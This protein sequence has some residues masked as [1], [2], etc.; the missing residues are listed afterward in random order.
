[1]EGAAGRTVSEVVE[2]PVPVRLEHLGVDVEAAVAE[3]CDFLC[4]EGGAAAEGAPAEWSELASGRPRR[5]IV[6]RQVGRRAKR[7]L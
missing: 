5:A 1:M 2:H 3:L 7:L 4:L 6:G